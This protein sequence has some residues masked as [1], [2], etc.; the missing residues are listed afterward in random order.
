[1]F[2]VAVT[3]VFE[4]SCVLCC[5]DG[6]LAVRHDEKLEEKIKVSQFSCILFDAHCLAWPDPSLVLGL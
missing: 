5:S 4:V 3:V 6:P 2:F 1:V